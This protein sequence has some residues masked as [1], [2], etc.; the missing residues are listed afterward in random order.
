[1]RIKLLVGTDYKDL[2]DQINEAVKSQN[3][4]KVDVNFETI[5]LR[6]GL[7]TKRKENCS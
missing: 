1:M 7:F 6:I 4:A 5:S 3:D 2:E